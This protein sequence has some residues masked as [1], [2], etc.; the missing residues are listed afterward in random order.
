M[1]PAECVTRQT[2]SEPCEGATL[3]DT[4]L[5]RLSGTYRVPLFQPTRQFIRPEKSIYRL[6]IWL[7]V[8]VCRSHQTA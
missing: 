7:S 8:Y 3:A 2:H 4:N 1:I 5:I 6:P